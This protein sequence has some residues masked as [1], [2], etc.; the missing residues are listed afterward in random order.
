MDLL[1][2]EI[3]S[4]WAD[5]YLDYKLLQRILYP[6]KVFDCEKVNNEENKENHDNINKKDN[7]DNINNSLNEH[8]LSNNEQKEEEKIQKINTINIE[9][10]FNKYISQLSLEIDKFSY[11]NDVLQTKRHAKRFNEIIEQLAYIENHAT[12]KMFKQQL[13][14]SLKNFY[15]EISNYQLF[16][17]TNIKIKNMSFNE[18]EKYFNK[19]QS[20][21]D[22]HK[23]NIS[24]LQEKKAKINSVLQSA[25]EYNHKLL[26]DIEEQYSLYFQNVYKHEKK[27]PIEILKNFLTPEKEKAEKDNIRLLNILV[28][29]MFTLG[30]LCFIVDY[31]LEINI[32]E[33][34]EFRSIFPMYRTYGIICLYL[35]TLGL[36]VWVWNKAS[37]NYKALFTFDNHYSTEV[38]IFIRAAFFSNLLFL[39]F[40]I[41]MIA[42]TTRGSTYFNFSN[43]INYSIDGILPGIIWFILIAYFFWPFKNFNYDGRIYTMRLFGECI[44]SILIPIEFKHIWFMD[45]LTSLIGPMRDIEYTLCYYSY[46]VNPFQTRELFCSN[47]RTIYLIIA[48]F[49]NLFRCLQ[50]GR[51]IIDN[52]KVCPYIFNIGKYTFN[53]IVATFSFLSMSHP[54]FIILW[55]ITAFISG[56]YSSFWDIKMDFGYFEK[57]SKNWPLRDQLKLKN[58]TLCLI[59]IPIDI[60]LRFLWMLSISHEIMIQIIK[61]EFLALI[62]YTLEMIRRAQW[63][64]IRVEFEHFELVKGYQISYYEELPL[65]K[66]SNGKFTTNEHNLLNIINIEK[67]DRMRL[68]LRELFNALE[69]DKENGPVKN[70]NSLAHMKEEKKYANSIVNQ[71]NEYLV[72]YRN[73]TKNNL[74]YN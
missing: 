43:N 69:K 4:E 45:Q 56:C 10:I 41:H 8:L 5:F 62:L 47:A 67:H 23:L 14:E 64:F 39:A 51:Q 66:L 60:I 58:R 59:A 48:I 57:G 54:N 44:A 27:T 15:R 34:P 20:L 2:K 74:V 72:N 55:I 36:N 68:E 52:G 16:I 26:R 33:D 3:I 38:E 40:L 71:L 29:S 1:E 19:I 25:D 70:E 46:Y 35:W 50:V 24:N 22:N 18:I 65:I 53:I 28:L 32:D 9:K 73:D 31:H 13:G 21:T 42:H 61:P 6:L 37:I 63:N 11:F 12:M 49:P 17:D 7:I 30:M